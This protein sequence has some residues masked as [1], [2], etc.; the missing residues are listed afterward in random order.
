[1][2]WTLPHIRD[3]QLFVILFIIDIVLNVAAAVAASATGALVNNKQHATPFVL[4]TAALAGL[5][6]AGALAVFGLVTDKQLT[7]PERAVLLMGFSKIAVAMVA[8]VL[9]ANRAKR[10]EEAN[11]VILLFGKDLGD[12]LGA[13]TIAAILWLVES[14]GI[15]LDRWLD[16]ERSVSTGHR[17]KRLLSSIK[18]LLLRPRNP[19]LAF[20]KYIILYIWVIIL[21]TLIGVTF[22][23]MAKVLVGKHRKSNLFERCGGSGWSS[24]WVHLW[25]VNCHGRDSELSREG[26]KSN[27]EAGN[28]G[29]KF[30]DFR[31]EF[32]IDRNGIH[33]K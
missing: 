10:T 27:D 11:A 29:Y 13:A 2:S 12:Y 3:I 23:Q 4:Q 19:L 1:M 5:T 15:H 25:S 26:V 30:V 22:A 6:K 14:Y 7:V 32:R 21:D 16:Q 17:F 28:T 24:V 9:V 33:A 31:T 8:T 20:R 18:A